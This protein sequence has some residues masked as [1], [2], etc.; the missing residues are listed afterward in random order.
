MDKKLPQL[1]D[2]SIRL[3]LNVAKVYTCFGDTFP[4]DSDFWNKLVL[5]EEEHAYL[6]KMEKSTFLTP[7]Q[8]PS[9]FLVSSVK[10]LCETNNMLI[11]VLK[12]YNEKPPS[13]ESAFNIA[14]DI[15]KSAGEDHYQRAMEQSTTSSTM[16][17]L[18]I[19]NKGCKNHA[20]RI[21]TY[22]SDKG[23]KIQDN[24]QGQQA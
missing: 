15:E 20:D 3:E 16:E 17:T 4:E 11:S 6:I 21:S 10:M 8:F 22:M 24:K 14:L 7:H 9:E 2:E 1:I 5:E 19:L 23:I 18:Q 13:R 12:E